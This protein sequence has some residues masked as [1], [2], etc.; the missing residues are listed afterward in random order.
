MLLGVTV[1][2]KEGAGRS[3][4]DAGHEVP[5]QLPVQLGVTVAEKEG[6]ARSEGDGGHE[7][8]G[9]ELHGESPEQIEGW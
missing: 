2:E 6:A 1:A 9:V 3:E 5:P 4:G 8:E 7:R